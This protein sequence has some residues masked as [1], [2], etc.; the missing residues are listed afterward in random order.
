LSK[1]QAAGQ[2]YIISAPSGAGKTSLIAAL[3][4]RVDNLV[5]SISYTTRAPRSLEK[6]DVDYFFVDEEKFIAMRDAQLFLEHAQV[7]GHHYGTAKSW[8]EET[9][10]QGKDIILEL[11]WQ[12]HRAI[13]AIYPEAKGIFIL[14]PSKQTLLE[15]LT[16]RGQDAPEVI[17][18]RMQQA[19]EEISHYNEYEYIVVNQ[20]L[21]LA[22]HDVIAIIQ[23]ARLRLARQR[24]DQSELINSLLPG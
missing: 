4:Q 21:A 1:S 24:I 13:K 2:L 15:R 16:G 10:A 20:D 23:A 6:P 8:V 17:A 18:H 19:S 7:F 12:G 9:L 3:L 22:T 14:P 5:M 11:D